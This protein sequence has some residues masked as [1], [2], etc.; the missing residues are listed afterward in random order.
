MA[1]V[2][3]LMKGMLIAMTVLAPA[4]SS[5]Q[6][7]VV[8]PTSAPSPLDRWHDLIAEA[9]HRFGIPEAWIRAVIRAESGGQTMLDGRP[10]TSRAGAMGPMQIMPETWAELGGRYG[11]GDDP[12]DP[13]DNILAGTAYLRELYVRYGYPNLF[14]AYNAGPARLDAHL[15]NGQPLPGETLTYLATLGQPIFEPVKSSLI[16]SGTG[17]FFSLRGVGSTASNPPTTLS[18][19]ALFVSSPP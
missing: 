15:F 4:I 6:S 17:L 11:L 10:I 12:Y 8:P 9:S 7:M 3:G 2:K 13:H 19:G 14:A 18:P 5:A 1:A 16:P